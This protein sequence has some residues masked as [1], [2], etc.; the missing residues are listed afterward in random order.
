MPTYKIKLIPSDV[1]HL[2]KKI[3]S[4]GSHSELIVKL[5]KFFPKLNMGRH[6][7]YITNR[8]TNKKTIFNLPMYIYNNDSP[9]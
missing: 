9:I 2:P 8:D 7:I 1:K 6:T 4:S 3:R 5:I